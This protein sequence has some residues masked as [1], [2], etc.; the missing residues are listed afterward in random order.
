MGREQV[1]VERRVRVHRRRRRRSA[2]R[3][4]R[5][6]RAGR[7]ARSRGRLLGLGR[8]RE[9]D[10]A[11]DLLAARRVWPRLCDAGRGRG[12]RARDEYSRLDAG[13]PE[14]DR[15]VADDVREQL[16]GRRR[17]DALV[18]ELVVDRHRLGE[19]DAVGGDDRAARPADVSRG[20]CAC[21][22]GRRRACCC[23]TTWR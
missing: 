12:P 16:R 9:H 21:C 15:L 19:H 4:R 17:V 22:A 18:L 20:T 14:L 5:P 11:G 13:R 23:R 10:G 1:R 7:R 6:S 3:A 2:R 8:Q